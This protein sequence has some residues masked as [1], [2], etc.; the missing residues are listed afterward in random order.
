TF[1][2]FL[3]LKTAENSAFINPDNGVR[4]YG[5]CVEPAAAFLFLRRGHMSKARK[6]YGLLFILLL[7]TP[8]AMAQ[9]FTGNIDGRVNDASGA[10]IPGVKFTLTSPAIQGS[11]QAISG[12]TG[13]YQFRLL[14]AGTYALKFELP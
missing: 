3:K 6:L 10:V 13:I 9:E 7:V 1:P 2:D 4:D 11:R 14:P 12:E 5:I 8:A